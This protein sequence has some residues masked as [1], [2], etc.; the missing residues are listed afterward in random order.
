MRVE[1]FEDLV[2]WQKARELAGD[3]YRVTTEREFGRD[4]A[5]ARQMQ[6]A[7]V[8]IMAN[9]AEGFGR[10]GAGEFHRFITIARGSCFELL[11]HVYLATDLAYV[12]HE[13]FHRLASRLDELSRILRAFRHRLERA[14]RET[15]PKRL[16]D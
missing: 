16:S 1:R 8:S 12:S 6:R 4:F 2:A 7:A 5:L 14:K 13:E 15:S 9:I 11:S 10:Q 3:V